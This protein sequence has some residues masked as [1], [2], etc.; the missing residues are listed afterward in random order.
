M[1]CASESSQ[2]PVSEQDGQ[3]G[4]SIVSAAGSDPK[5]YMQNTS[6]RDSE[7]DLVPVESL[8]KDHRMYTPTQQQ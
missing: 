7:G 5:C 1:A 2:I 3:N 8:A 4:A 6:F